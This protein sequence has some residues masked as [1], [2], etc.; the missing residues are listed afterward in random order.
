MPYIPENRREE[1][2]VPLLA[3]NATQR[4]AD[5]ADLLDSVL[6]ILSAYEEAAKPSDD[7]NWTDEAANLR[8]ALCALRDGPNVGDL[9]YTITRFLEGVVIGDEV[10]YSKINLCA[11]LLSTLRTASAPILSG[12]GGLPAFD[13]LV[14]CMGVLRCCE[15]EFLRRLHDPYEDACI[16]KNGDCFRHFSEGHTRP[17]EWSEAGI[18]NIAA[19]F[20]AR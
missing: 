6:L 3:F 8:D 7:F 14:D 16:K 15:H 10:R 2:E 12:F 9:N 4:G 1:L 20:A 19:R 5:R 18:G 11:G 13:R 17:K